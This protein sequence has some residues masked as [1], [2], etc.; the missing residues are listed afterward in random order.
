[1][2]DTRANIDD[3]ESNAEVP[4]TD[5]QEKRTFAD[6][7]N[8]LRGRGEWDRMQYLTL[9]IVL[10]WVI[11]SFNYILVVFIYFYEIMT[12]NNFLIDSD[13]PKM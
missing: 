1:M 4:E 9:W 8:D 13:F 7:R 3:G 10:F 6:F 12:C 2:V 11:N 5:T